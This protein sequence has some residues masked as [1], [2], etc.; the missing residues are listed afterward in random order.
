ME[1]AAFPNPALEFEECGATGPSKL[2][3]PGG[4][5]TAQ[6]R[7]V[8]EARIAAVEQ[9]SSL[10]G[11]GDTE[12]A[13]VVVTRRLRGRSAGDDDSNDADD[14]NAAEAAE[15]FARGLHDKFGV[16]DGKCH[17]GAV[18]LI[19]LRDRQTYLSTGSGLRE[20]FLS[21][22]RSGKILEAMGPL[23]GA[24]DVA[25]AVL[26]ALDGIRAY[27]ELGAPSLGERF[28][29][30]LPQILFFVFFGAVVA[31]IFRAAS[32]P[33]R[34]AAWKHLRAVEALRDAG[35]D[36]L[37]SICLEPLASSDGEAVEAIVN[38]GHTFHRDC[39][40]KWFDSR[41]EH[42]MTC[43]VCRQNVEPPSNHAVLS[44]HAAAGAAAGG[45][46][47]SVEPVVRFRLDRIRERYP[48]VVTRRHLD[49]WRS[50]NYAGTLYAGTLDLD[51]RT[52]SSSPPSFSSFGG[53]HSSGGAGRSF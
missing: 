49:A 36:D 2:C 46:A 47:A 32:D 41:D 30:A 9:A 37:C 14:S 19:A 6:A 3:D 15:A 17:T 43:P 11:C 26:E 40:R 52:S 13:V 50:R 21:D 45:T 38:C 7:A 23:L 16:G 33:Q 20:S 51:R 29:E 42:V 22:H 53:G 34:D 1:V 8:V 28:Q 25:G 48:R 35:Q 27:A 5:M 10:R 24:G 12:I 18:L 4:V 31:S 44:R 39:L